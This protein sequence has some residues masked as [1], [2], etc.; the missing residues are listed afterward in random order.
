MLEK[1]ESCAPRNLGTVAMKT[2]HNGRQDLRP[3]SHT[4]VLHSHGML[5]AKPEYLQAFD[6]A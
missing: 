1:F 6:R 4:P 5:L 2:L 3:T